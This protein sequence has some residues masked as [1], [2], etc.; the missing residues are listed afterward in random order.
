MCLPVTLA[1]ESID[2][3]RVLG[4]SGQAALSEALLLVQWETVLKV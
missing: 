1:I 2:V 4:I 3:G